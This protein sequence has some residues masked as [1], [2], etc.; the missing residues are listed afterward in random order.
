MTIFTGTLLPEP[1]MIIHK[2]EKTSFDQKELTIRILIGKCIIIV[3]LLEKFFP[4]S[5][6]GFVLLPK[7]AQTNKRPCI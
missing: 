7:H 5:S 3:R 1:C 2:T 6:S 4:E